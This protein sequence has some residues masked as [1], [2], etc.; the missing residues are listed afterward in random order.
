MAIQTDK[1]RK[2]L[3][4]FLL[5]TALLATI[6]FIFIYSASSVFALE[7]FGSEMY[8]LKKQLTYLIP[9]IIGFFFFASIPTNFLKKWSPYLFIGALFLTA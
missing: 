7:K 5:L 9:S 6:G 1:I 3:R 8:F 2:D 4:V